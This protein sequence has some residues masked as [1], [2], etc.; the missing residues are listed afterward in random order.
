MNQRQILLNEVSVL[1]H[2][3]QEFCW[4]EM[5]VEY[6]KYFEEK[7]HLS[8]LFLFSFLFFALLLSIY[9]F[10]F[11]FFILF[12]FWF[13]FFSESFCWVLPNNAFITLP[14]IMSSRLIWKKKKN[15]SPTFMVLCKQKKNCL[16]LLVCVLSLSLWYYEKYFYY[17]VNKKELLKL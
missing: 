8:V 14:T 9:F 4:L 13:F 10:H 17:P 7:P 11:P 12:V 5:G 3:M 1:L 2:L 15:K 6:C 16:V